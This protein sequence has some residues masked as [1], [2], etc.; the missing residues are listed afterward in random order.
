VTIQEHHARQVAISTLLDLTGMAAAYSQHNRLVY[1]NEA[2]LELWNLSRDDLGR[3]VS[4]LI[5]KMAPQIMEGADTMRQ[6]VE[7]GSLVV[8]HVLQLA[9][10]PPR[11]VRYRS[12]TTD[13]SQGATIGRIAVCLDV[14]EE[15]EVRRGRDAFLSLIGH[16]FKT[17]ITIIDGMVD[18]LIQQGSALEKE[19]ATNLHT[20]QKESWRLSRLL[21]EILAAA[22]LQ[23]PDWAPGS[24]LVDL[25]AVTKSEIDVRQQLYTG[26]VWKYRGPATL[27]VFGDRESLTMVTQALLSNANRFSGMLFP[28]E[29]DIVSYT[30]FVELIVK[31][32]GPGVSPDMV[33]DLFTS[34]PSPTKRT[35]SGGIGLG[36][37]VARK[38]LDRL[39]GDIQYR[40]REEGGSVFTVRFPAAPTE[41]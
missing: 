32:R 16:E 6:I 26:R 36:L 40:P 41:V 19:V 20:I 10:V 21:K 22:Q 8:D 37:Y 28:V 24:E 9:T 39:G 1:A 13:P 11:Y 31:D 3:D 25:V 23:D 33:S 35:P 30:N 27:M 17:P 38:I 2:F 15:V 18:W 14:T 12:Q 34:I 7:D 29:I 4:D 5:D